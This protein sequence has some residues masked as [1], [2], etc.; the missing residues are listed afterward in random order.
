MAVVVVVSHGETEKK[1]G[2][3]NNEHNTK[4]NEDIIIWS[5][6]FFDDI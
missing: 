6:L 5:L 3:G 4:N 2:D 1:V